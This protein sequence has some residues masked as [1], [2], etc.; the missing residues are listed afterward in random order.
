MFHGLI[1][2]L[3][4]SQND[5]LSCEV[6]QVGQFS[7]DDHTCNDDDPD[8]DPDDDDASDDNDCNHDCFCTSA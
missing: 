2:K 5:K 4:A 6:T 7:P 3:L 8:D 1:P